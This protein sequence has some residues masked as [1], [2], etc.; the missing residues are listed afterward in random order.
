VEFAEDGNTAALTLTVAH[1]GLFTT[2]TMKEKFNQLETLYYPSTI[3]E[4]EMLVLGGNQNWN[5]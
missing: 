4:D 3:G 5:L 1:P 2:R